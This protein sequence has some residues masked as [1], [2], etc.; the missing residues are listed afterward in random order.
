MAE[1]FMYIPSL[2][3]CIILAYFIMKFIKV[4]KETKTKL[5][6]AKENS[7]QFFSR[8]RSVLG[9]V[10]LIL[11]LYSFKTIS[12]NRDWKD[13]LTIYR[14]DVA[15]SENSATAHSIFGQALLTYAYP[16]E[17]NNEQRLAIV[18]SSI[19]E[20][21]KAITIFPDDPI[22]YRYLGMAF[23]KKNDFQN[24][25]KYFEIC[26]KK[27]PVTNVYDMKQLGYLY[28][29]TNQYDRALSVLDSVLIREPDQE[30]WNYKGYI[31]FA[32]GKYAD[33][34]AAYK[35]TLELN[36][37]SLIAYQNIGAAYINLNDYSQALQFLLKA[38]AIDSTNSNT[39]N[40]LSL[41]Y[42][43]KGD[44]EKANKYAEKA[45]KFKKENQQ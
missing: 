28:M 34:I 13:D 36:E 25:S 16:N 37:N 27:S 11:M 33:A 26:L 15:I 17:T 12:R 30:A 23:E 8:S 45:E 2:G 10:F 1:R 18:D 4:A 5:L 24:A 7:S 41:A 39:I 40:K 35:K 9:T 21:N 22:T 44:K 6:A 19:T 31:L 42:Q 20:L 32:T 43:L 3:F 14:H 38:E 29:K